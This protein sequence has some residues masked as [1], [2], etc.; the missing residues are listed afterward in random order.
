M[1]GKSHNARYNEMKGVGLVDSAFTPRSV[2]MWY[3]EVY[4]PNARVT[5]GDQVGHEIATVY[6]PQPC[7]RS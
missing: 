1:K 2:V 3:M 6:I 4:D 7:L 5:L